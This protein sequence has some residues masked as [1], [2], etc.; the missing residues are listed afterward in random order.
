MCIELEA[1]CKIRIAKIYM[2]GKS[3][4]AARC[5]YLCLVLKNRGKYEVLDAVQD[6]DGHG[7]LLSASLCAGS[8]LARP[9]ASPPS[10]AGTRG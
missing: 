3:A 10:G 9:L 8:D 1:D 5:D 2:G 7:A 4:D 6:M